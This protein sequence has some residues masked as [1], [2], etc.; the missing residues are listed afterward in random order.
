MSVGAGQYL[1]GIRTLQC[2]ERRCRVDAETGCW[3]WLGSTVAEGTPTARIDGKCQSVRRWALS[4]TR[5]LQ[6]GRVF[7]VPKCGHQTC[8]APDHAASLRGG[9]Y[10]R[11]LNEIGA[12]NTPAQKQRVK[13]ASRARKVI[14]K[15]TPAKAVELA[16]RI[17]AGEDRATVAASYGVSTVH[18]NKVALGWHWGEYVRAALGLAV[19]P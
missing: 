4:R 9:A 12:T 3:H 16:Q 13:D 8:V 17:H 6:T 5:K 18:A 19:P 15:L 11:W 2:I 7:V 14:V 1:G 10:M